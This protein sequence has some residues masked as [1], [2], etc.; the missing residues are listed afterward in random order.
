M[1]ELPEVETIV[2]ELRTRLTRRRVESATVERADVVHGDPRPLEALLAGRLVKTVDR[3]A[4]RIIIELTRNLRLVFHLGMSGR[5]TI[6]DHDNPIAKHTHV[7]IGFGR[8]IGEL[9]FR[10]PR[11]F[12]GVW[13]LTDA[14]EYVGKRLGRLGPEPLELAAKGFRRILA[15][16][17][18]IKALLLDQSKI[19]G[20]GNIYTDEAL[21]AAGVHPMTPADA[22]AEPIAGQLLRAIKQTL[23]RAIRARGSTLMDYRTVNGLEGSFQRQHRVYGRTGQPCH[24]CG[25]PIERIIVAG[26]STC[27]C[28]RCQ[29][30]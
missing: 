25:A 5:L 15:S 9:R 18:Q 6:D 30:L 4:K 29:P 24:K 7:R 13:V 21:Y 2:R 19:A 10:D 23:R 12:G 20:L 11:R 26:R 1:P 8:E 17:R 22:L 27:F 28:P 3:R 16:R 14:G